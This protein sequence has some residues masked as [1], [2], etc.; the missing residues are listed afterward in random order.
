M[1]TWWQSL[2]RVVS[3]LHPVP[4]EIATWL[5]RG[6]ELRAVVA[7]R[8]SVLRTPDFGGGSPFRGASVEDTEPA[9]GDLDKVSN[10]LLKFI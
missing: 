1:H 3:A 4:A 9:T 7:A 8:P 10:C 2:L 6:R 5:E